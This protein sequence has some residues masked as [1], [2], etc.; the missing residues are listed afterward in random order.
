MTP[1]QIKALHRLV[2]ALDE[3][4]GQVD[5]FTHG[6]THRKAAAAI[7]EG[8][9]L[10]EQMRAAPD[11]TTGHCAEK[12]KPGGCQLHNLHCGY[13]ACDRRAAPK[14]AAQEPAEAQEPIAWM[15][16]WDADGEVVRDWVSRDYDEAHSPT[17]GCHNIRPLYTAPQPVRKPLTDAEIREAFSVH[18][19]SYPWMSSMY[20]FEAGIRYAEAAHGI[21]GEA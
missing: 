19:K 10:I 4:L 12:N 2:D 11:Y 16:D 5:Q 18:D 14:Q 20:S 8:R 6:N 21:K 17:N 13:P 15:Y 3:A 7:T 9:A 1:N